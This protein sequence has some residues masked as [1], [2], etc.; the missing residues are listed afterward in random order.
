MGMDRP[1]AMRRIG[2]GCCRI[3]SQE[4]RVILPLVRTLVMIVVNEGCQCALQRSLTEKYEVIE[5]FF[6][7]RSYETP[8]QMH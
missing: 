6:L 2:V 7:D 1:G 8:L 4:D 3:G 5:A